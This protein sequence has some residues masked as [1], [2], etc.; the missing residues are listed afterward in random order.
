MGEGAER[1]GA[2]VGVAGGEEWALTLPAFFFVQGYKEFFI[3]DPRA[4]LTIQPAHPL[5]FNATGER[6]GRVE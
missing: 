6:C 3:F 4:L 5:W 2:G 1:G